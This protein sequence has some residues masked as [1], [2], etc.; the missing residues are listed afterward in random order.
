MRF[1]SERSNEICGTI[2]GDMSRAPFSVNKAARCKDIGSSTIHHDDG[3]G[4]LAPQ[5]GNPAILIQ[6]VTRAPKWS[7]LNHGVAAFSR[8]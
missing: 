4:T 2:A 1:N 8:Q 6:I 7:R 3:A 5:A